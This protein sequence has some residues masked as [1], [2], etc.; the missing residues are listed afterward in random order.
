M[1]DSA[2][3]DEEALRT[4]ATR[5]ACRPKGPVAAVPDLR[6]RQV[7]HRRRR[8]A[9]R[10]SPAST[11]R[12]RSSCS[13]SRAGSTRSRSPRSRASPTPQ[14]AA[15][16][17]GR[18]CP[19]P[20]RRDRRGSRRAK[21]AKRHELVHLVP[22]RLPAR[23]RRHRALRRQLR[24]R[25]LALDH[26]RAAHARARDA[27]HAR[28]EPAPGA[29]LDRR[30]G[31]RD[32]RRSPRSSGS[33][34]GL[35]ARQGPVQALRRRRLHAAEQR[36]RLRARARS[37][38]A[39]ARRASSSRWSRACGRRSARRACRRSPPC[40][41]A[42]RCPRRASRA[43][44][45]PG[46]IAAHRARL[47]RAPLRALRAAASARRA[48]LVWMGIG[49]LL[50]FI[51]V[52]M[53]SVRLVRPLARRARLAGDAASAAPPASL[54]RDNAR[55]NPQRTASTAAALM[56]GLALVTLVA[57]LAAGITLELPRRGRQDLANADYAITAQNNFTPIPTAAADA[58]AK[59]PGR[60]GG[61]QR[62]H[63]RRERVRQAR[64]S[65]PPSTRPASTMFTA[66]LERRARSRR[67]R[68]LG[69]DGAF[70]DKGYAKTHHLQRRLAARAH[71]R[72]RQPQD[73]RGQGHLRPAA[74]AARR[75]AA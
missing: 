53:L 9:A 58:A 74:R 28:R 23:V 41:R 65:R 70:V 55:R 13:T 3:A 20:R 12:P 48:I 75:S 11:C 17:S 60:R 45:P 15:A 30:R 57:V 56:I 19:R 33:F 5:S 43:S 73:V 67:W 6:D 69:D 42:R 61:R 8:S 50:I 54:A 21:D 27:A 59:T 7:R 49:A 62:P 1:I 36:P 39:L 66:R 47:R 37:S 38:I 46:S 34:V 51:G 40:A 18:S 52:A 44:A 72:E 24:D 25:E 71:L 2:R 68:T 29:D 26:D 63:R 35:G 10:R 4:S 31:A 64:S 22:A 14:L 16:R 32:R